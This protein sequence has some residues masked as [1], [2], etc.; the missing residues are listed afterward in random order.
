MGK[1]RQ[2]SSKFL[3]RAPE[4]AGHHVAASCPAAGRCQ[5]GVF[6][7]RTK[8]QPDLV[9]VATDKLPP[10]HDFVMI[11]DATWDAI[12]A[13]R[14]GVP[15]IG[16][17][18]GGLERR[19]CSGRAAGRSTPTPLTSPPTSQ[20]RFA[21]CRSP[22]CDLCRLRGSN[23]PTACARALILIDDPQHRTLLPVRGG[24]RLGWPSRAPFEESCHEL[25]EGWNRHRRPDLRRVWLVE[26]PRCDQL[27][28]GDN[29]DRDHDQLG[30]RRRRDPTDPRVEKKTIRWP[31]RRPLGSG[32]VSAVE[33]SPAAP[34]R[35]GR[36]RT[37]V[38]V[39]TRRLAVPK[40]AKG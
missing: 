1:H 28:W 9:S 19:N 16:L 34:L 5:T 33:G 29:H 14:V 13:A 3:R 25:A 21:S 23:D 15:T 39:F 2:L 32:L 20:A 7:D 6:V 22:K 12:A 40:P 37:Q 35:H 36:S 30:Q 4:D 18:S 10:C 8:P 38:G 31:T 26:T 17:L 24:A 27:D 11:G